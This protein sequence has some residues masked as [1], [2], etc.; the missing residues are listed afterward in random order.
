[1]AA[2]P[3]VEKLQE[4]GLRHGEKLAMGVVAAVFVLCAYL[5]WSHESLP[6]TADEVATSAKKAQQNIG[7]PQ[8]NEDILAKLEQDGVKLAHFE[9]AVD[10]RLAGGVDASKYSLT[11]SFVSPEPG[12]GLIRDMPEFLAP[13][14]LYVHSSRGAVRVFKLDEDGNPILKPTKEEPKPRRKKNAA[15]GG[16]LG[17]MGAMGG[18]GSPKR[19][20]KTGALEALQ[21]KKDEENEQHRKNAMIAGGDDKAK[22]EETAEEGPVSTNVED[23][24][25]ENKGYRLVTLVGKF[26]H[27]KQR[28]LYSK[29]LKED[30]ASSNPN[31]LRLEVERQEL[32]GDG[33]WGDWKPIN[34][35]A[36]DE[37][38]EIKTKLEDEVVPVESRIE[39][40]IDPVPF[41]EVG[42]MYGIHHASLVPKELLRPKVEAKAKNKSGG[43]A[44]FLRPGGAMGGSEF[45]GMEDYKKAGMGVPPGGGDYGKGMMGGGGGGG[46][47][48]GG[49]DG[50]GGGGGLLGGTG[51]RPGGPSGGDFQK[52]SADL[53]MVR[54]VDFDVEPN[55]NYRYR[56][57]VVFANPN[58]G[59]ENVI[60][61][62]DNHSKEKVGPWCETSDE[63]TVPADVAT[64]A[65][66][67]ALTP[68][69]NRSDAVQFQVVKW[70]PEDGLTIVKNFD[71]VPGQ[72]IG[73][74][75]SAMVP[76][77]EGGNLTSAQIDFTSHQILA[78]IL[79]GTHKPDE[80]Q[81]LGTPNF[82][83]PTLALVVRPDGMLVLRD[84]ARDV[85][86]GEMAELKEIYEQ[87][88][89][90]A[91]AG[92]KKKGS[93]ALG[94][95]GPLGGAAGGGGRAGA[96]S[97]R[98]IMP[99]DGRAPARPPC[100]PRDMVPV[101]S[102][103]SRDRTGTMSRFA[104]GPIPG[105][106]SKYA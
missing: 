18:S 63:V 85:N 81:G 55:A 24:E 71:Q 38:M 44:G 15:R 91:T 103:P 7:K 19:K 62:L 26:D 29:A 39:T 43:A 31:Y 64:Y 52:S 69:E 94:P 3:T 17:G 49:L 105:K 46:G 16:L 74:P 21:K 93:S 2:N 61:G 83:S 102:T 23:Y 92:G 101:R 41:F 77:K 35:E 13:E 25:L 70:N 6:M 34:R 80:I 47:G 82:K 48:L 5:A 33:Q 14:D 68:V 57:R 79:G 59:W 86:N 42:Y 50:P 32:Q 60:P 36:F 78:D 98:W 8:R 40:L 67:A 97:A 37:F 54:A 66:G 30:L 84:E 53:L 89:R 100:V 20:K 95:M 51:S 45:N 106:S 58:Y 22:A 73:R 99:D 10:A 11:E 104:P 88:K 65:I 27:K 75:E 28:E 87:I 96:D 4:F 12:A 90:D 56:A 1:M 76:R 9:K 72:V